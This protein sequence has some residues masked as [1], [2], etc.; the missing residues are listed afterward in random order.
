MVGQELVDLESEDL[1]TNLGI[2]G[3]SIK[4]NQMYLGVLSKIC[5]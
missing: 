3:F 4:Y 2:L 1:G 5:A